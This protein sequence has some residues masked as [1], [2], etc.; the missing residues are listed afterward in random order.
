MLVLLRFVALSLL[1][2]LYSEL[3]AML[4]FVCYPYFLHLGFR[5]FS[6]KA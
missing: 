4:Y 6:I 5:C 3:V 1:G 2:K